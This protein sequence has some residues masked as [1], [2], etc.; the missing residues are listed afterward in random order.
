MFVYTSGC[1]HI[2]AETHIGHGTATTAYLAHV[3]DILSLCRRQADLPYQLLHFSN[4]R[5]THLSQYY[6]LLQAYI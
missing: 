3:A 2:T 5:N 6:S 4:L 1:Q